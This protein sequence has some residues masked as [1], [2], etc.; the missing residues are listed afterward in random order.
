MYELKYEE[1]IT[2]TDS[3]IK[4]KIDEMINEINI[5]LAKYTDLSE[6]SINQ[7]KESVF[8]LEHD[9]N[10]IINLNT[11]KIDTISLENIKRLIDTSKNLNLTLKLLISGT[12]YYDE[13]KNNFVN[14]LFFD[15]S[16]IVFNKIN[17]FLSLNSQKELRFIDADEGRNYYWTLEEVSAANDGV[18]SVC[19]Y[20]KKCKFSPLEAIACIYRLATTTFEYLENEIDPIYARSLVGILNTEYCV[21]VGYS[22][23]INACVNKLNDPNLSCDSFVS[24]LFFDEDSTNPLQEYTSLSGW[25]MQNIITINDSLYNVVGS[26]IVDATC[27]C[28]SKYFPSGKG[29]GNF[30]FPVTDLCHLRGVSCRQYENFLDEISAIIGLENE[31]SSSLWVVEKY[32]DS[33]TPISCDVMKSCLTRLIN[34]IFYKS[35]EEDNLLRIDKILAVSNQIAQ[36]FFDSDAQNAFITK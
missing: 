1:I 11:T 3:Q 15:E 34:T 26:Y 7:F 18:N 23:F 31:N 6:S 21:C 29:Y 24:V 33:S 22:Y 12:D 35:S 8:N 19:D 36:H 16:F 25:H 4:N 32:K 17:E 5:G 30:M 10:V 27:D 20:V 2:L 13:N 28:K 14:L 9:L